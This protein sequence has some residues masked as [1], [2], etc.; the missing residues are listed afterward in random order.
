[1]CHNPEIRVHVHLSFGLVGWG[2][3]I[4]TKGPPTPALVSGGSIRF[5]QHVVNFKPCVHSLSIVEAT[6]I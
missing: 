3:I 1:M 5:S 6:P 4:L 2:K